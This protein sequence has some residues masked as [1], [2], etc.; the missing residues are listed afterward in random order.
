MIN[1]HNY[2]IP[3]N[4]HV[5]K[6]SPPPFPYNAYP[7][8]TSGECCYNEWDHVFKVIKFPLNHPEKSVLC[9]P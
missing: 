7:N 6:Q 1:I 5:H 4:L 2:K 8:V 3:I 9:A